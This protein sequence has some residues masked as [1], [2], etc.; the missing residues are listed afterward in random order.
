MAFKRGH[1]PTNEAT[2]QSAGE[3]QMMSGR[4]LVRRTH[5]MA[6]RKGRRMG[7]RG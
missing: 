5:K 7:K 4:A 2:A 3:Q 6:K 1:E